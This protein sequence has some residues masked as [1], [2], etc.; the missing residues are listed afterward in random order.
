MGE[1]RTIPQRTRRAV[2]RAMDWGCLVTI[3]TGRGFRPTARFAQDLGLNAPLI[4][5]QG[6]LI[7]D[8]R[9]GTIVH[10]STIPLDVAQQV[11]AFSQ[12]RQLNGQVYMGDERAYAGQIDPIMARIAELSGVPVTAVGDL[13]VWLEQPPLKFL[14]FE[15]KQAVPG[16]VRDLQTLFNGRLQVVRS[17]DEIVEVTGPGVSKGDAL[18][19][20]A[21]HLGVPQSATMAVGDQ[22]NDVSMIAWAELGVAMG[23]ASPAAKAA[24][25]VIA[26]PVAEEGA[27]WAIEQLALEE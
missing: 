3:A 21:V 9:D 10:S 19:R 13:A 14:F 17:W 8:H 18:A 26:P 2:R 22:D 11:I 25:G 4:C 16:L 20:L 24:A 15:R 12:A 7:Q 23:N 27:A 6:A 5:Y 1:A